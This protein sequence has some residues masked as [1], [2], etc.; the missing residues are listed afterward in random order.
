MELS[1]RLFSAVCIIADDR[2]DTQTIR[3]PCER[4]NNHWSIDAAASVT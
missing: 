1:S 2:E 4:E 3:I